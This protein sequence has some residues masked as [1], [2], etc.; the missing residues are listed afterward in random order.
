[1]LFNTVDF[2]IFF[3]TVLLLYWTVFKKSLRGQN[4]FLVAVS[5]LF[6]SFWDWRFVSLIFLSSVVDYFV[7]SFLGQT[8]NPFKRKML[9]WGSLLFNLGLLFTFKYFNFF[10]DTFVEAFSLLGTEMKG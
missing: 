2:A 6:Y 8:S 10:V 1:M 3:P 4:A 7:G 5:Y 9:L